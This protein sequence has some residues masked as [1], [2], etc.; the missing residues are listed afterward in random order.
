VA[1]LLASPFLFA[2]TAKAQNIIT[3]VAGG[4]ANSSVAASAEILVPASVAMDASGNA[5]IAASNMNQIFKMDS[6]GNIKVVAG[7]GTAGYSGDGGPATSASLTYPNGVA[8]DTS[9]NLF[10]ADT[11]NSVVRRVDASTGII[12]TVAGNG[13]YGYSGD[14]G[15]ATSATLTYA[16]SVAVD[17]SGNL[18]IADTAN[19]RVRR[20]AAATGVITT[21][22]G[23]GTAGFS[24][25]GGLATSAGLDSP[26]GVSVDASGNLFIADTVDN[27]VRRVDATTGIITTVA[28]SSSIGYSGDGGPAT[29][30]SLCNPFGV[31]VDTSGNLFIADMSNDRIRRVDAKT[32]II[33]TV[34]GNGTQGYSGDGG[35]ATGASLNGPRGVSVNAAGN[36]FIAD[37]YNQRIRCVAAATGVITTV[38]GGGSDGDGGPATSAFL[39]W[40]AGVAEDKSGNLFIADA[41]NSR[42]RRVDATT[43]IISTVVGNG[44]LGFSGDGGPATSASLNYPWGVAFDSSGNLFIADA[45]NN[46]IRR[47]D[48][49]T[50]FITTVAGSGGGGDGGPATSASL[51]WP[52]DVALD[53]SGNLF[54]ADSDDNRIRRVDASTGIITTVAG[55]GTYGFSGDGGPATSASLRDPQG[56][57]V[58][59][60]GNLFIAD[61]TNF[62]VRRVDAATGIITTVA[63]NGIQ[64]F[65]GDGGPA[66]SASLSMV[67]GVAV[68]A[69]GNLFIADFGNKRIRRVDATTGTITTVA[70]NGINGYSGDGGPAT[71]ASL[72][73]PWSVSGETPGR[74]LIADTGNGRVRQVISAPTWQQVP[75]MLS[76]VSVGSDG[77]VWGLNSAGQAYF[78]NPQTQSWQQAPGL[79]TQIVVG[80]SGFVWGL[81]A[82]GQIYRYDPA[83]QSWD[84]IP[85]TLSQIAVGSDGDVWG[86]NSS[87]QVYHFNSATETWTQIPGALAQIAV[88]Y[89]GAIW[90]I[91][92]AQQ[93][94]R[95]NPGTQSW[96]QVPGS[97]KQIAV[98]ADGDVWGINNAGQIYHFNSLTQRWHN[99][100][101]SLAQ[102]A[103]GSASNVWGLDATGAVWCFN[104]QTQVWDQI[105]GQ[106]A[107]IAVGADGAVWGVNSADQIYQFVQP[108]EPTQTFLQVAGSLA[109]ISVGLDGEVWGIDA[110]QQ[111][112]C[113]DAQ[114]QSFEQISGTLSEIR[115]GFGGNVWGLNA[116]GQIYQ[117]NPSTKSWNQIPGSLAQLEVGA[118]GSVWG[119][120]A[121]GQIYQFNSSTQGWEQIPGSLAQLA[122][123]ADGTVWGINSVGQIYRFNPSTQGWVQIP[124]SLAQLAVGSANNVWGLNAAGQIYQFNSSTQ[125]WNQI[126]GSLA[127]LAVAF[128]GTVW[129]LNSANQI[130]RFNTAT[131]SWVSISGTLAQLSVGA[132]AVVWGLN[133]GGQ[134]YQYW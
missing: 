76:Q 103:V 23:D 94:Y 16:W 131:Q 107:Q 88:G 127:Q 121:A 7:N 32:L 91:N 129:G 42:I 54:V 5:F 105:P 93:I 4:G 84:Q 73:G 106:L 37:A 86:I 1:A 111:I 75:G 116:A 50:G 102:I 53:G 83:T 72:S 114:L 89:D 100:P 20:V 24:G 2:L 109:Q 18:F 67:A 79:L 125:T 92:A 90:G 124:G 19:N 30:A 38:A 33:T 62:R 28:G 118:N 65:G 12:T 31:A 119:L 71:S 123:G 48:A 59:A 68:D 63:G 98:G 99:T 3:T 112:W 13:N 82:S 78:F 52:C 8:V 85:G 74:L 87:A 45:E 69:S 11:N 108:T 110:T 101:G 133:A 21:V 6:V 55:N 115:V 58:D 17:A 57:A 22:A 27:R 36:L 134:A 97:L 10:I 128:D 26:R 51:N 77:T 49:S 47:V 122:V 35:P 15:P 14:G 41:F 44:T 117:F 29:S 60:Y 126:A 61:W 34:A 56:V 104:A 39:S 70:G 25:D 43:G 130:W 46:R 95:F 132:D 120:N 40:P 9:D 66:T 96:Q 80:A 81:N 113:Y 64:G